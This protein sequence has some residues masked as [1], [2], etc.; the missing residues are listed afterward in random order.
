MRAPPPYGLY[1][2][3]SQQN[4]Q[5]ATVAIR[6]REANVYRMEAERHR[7]T[8]SARLLSLGMR[9]VLVADAEA[10]NEGYFR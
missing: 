3:Q 4:R 8:L 7:R 6:K 9:Q 5:L 2:L 10:I 1:P